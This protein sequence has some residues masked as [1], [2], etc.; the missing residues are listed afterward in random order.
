MII[1]KH[2]AL[3]K[4]HGSNFKVKQGFTPLMCLLLKATMDF[5]NTLCQINCREWQHDTLKITAKMERHLYLQNR[6]GSQ[7]GIAPVHIL[8]ADVATR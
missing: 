4:L 7:S 3:S 1:N 5:E 2:Q 8:Y 6:G